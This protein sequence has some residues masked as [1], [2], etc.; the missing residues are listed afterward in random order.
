MD[1]KTED[2]ERFLDFFS[3]GRD[4]GLGSNQF[5]RIKI[6]SASLTSGNLREI[7][8]MSNDYGRGYA[9]VTD[10][11]DIQLHWI[12]GGKGPEIFARLEELGFT[13]DKCGQAYPGARYGD[14]RNIVV[15]PTAGIDRNEI[16]DIR[17][18]A[19]K[20]NG[21]FKGNRDFLDMPK[22]FK[23]SITGCDIGCTKPEIQDL[24]LFAVKSG[25]EAGFAALV[26]GGLGSTVPGPILARPLGVFIPQDDAFEVTRAMVEIHRDNSNRETKTKA[27]FKWLVNEWG[28]EKVRNV[29]HEK[30]GKELEPLEAIPRIS[31]EEHAG[32][33]EQ[34][35]GNYFVNVPLV[36]GILTSGQLTEIADI[37]DKLG[38]G[39][40]RTTSWQNF[41]LI[42]IPE[43]KLDIAK[44]RLKAAG[45]PLK[46]SLL[47][48][49]AVGCAADFCG[50]STEPHPKQMVN[51]IIEHLENRFGDAIDNLKLKLCVTGCSHDCGLRMIGNIGL[52]GVQTKKE[53]GGELYSI[54][55]CGRL[56]ENASLATM[57]VKALEPALVI[58]AIEKL[59]EA[60]IKEGYGDFAEYCLS[61]PL[62]ELI[63]IA[64]RK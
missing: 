57:A 41:L 4:R 1:I 59:V 3:L 56:G 64:K 8:R 46:G 52:L 30:L 13:T 35:D 53:G 31:G 20:I 39:E 38:S 2:L 26:G 61:R 29:L 18:L 27:R 6:P 10:R 51:N 50:K 25:G 15:C 55:L 58:E 32:T 17:P 36:G 5:L 54:Y 11:Q 62:E 23:I 37:A 60:C 19:G 49:T 9:E 16:I 34:K 12:D 44:Q 14:V 48:W 47:R 7:A 22:K 40:I 21:F 33:Q 42:N 45:M 24:G 43:S 28:V 63:E